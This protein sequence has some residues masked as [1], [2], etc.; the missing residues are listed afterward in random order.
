[1]RENADGEYR[2]LGGATDRA[3]GAGGPSDDPRRG[4]PVHIG[5]HGPWLRAAL[6][7]LR[8]PEREGLVLAIGNPGGGPRR[9]RLS[10]AD[11]ERFRRFGELLEA[12][13]RQQAADGSTQDPDWPARYSVSPSC[14]SS[15]CV[16]SH[17]ACASAP[18]TMPS[19][20]WELP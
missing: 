9:Y 7:A 13:L 20:S 11:E 18:W 10:R 1:M 8:S 19:N 2:S 12:I 6:G 3:T 16:S 15:S 17:S 5:G 4:R 14:G